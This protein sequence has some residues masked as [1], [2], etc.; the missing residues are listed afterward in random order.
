[1]SPGSLPRALGSRGH[2]VAV[3]M[4]YYRG[5]RIGKRPP[6]KTK[7]VVPVSVGERVLACRLYTSTLAASDVPIY[8]IDQPEYFDRD[9][10]VTGAGLYQQSMP[11]GYKS[12][13]PDNAERFAFFSR[14]VLEAP[15][16][17]ASLRILSMRT[18]G[19]PASCRCFSN[20]VF[21]ARAGWEK[22][23]S[24]FTIHN[25]AYQGMFGARRDAAHRP[26]RLALQP[27]A[28]RIP[29]PL[30]LPEVRHRLR[31][32]RQHRQPHLRPGDPDQP[33]SA[34]ASK[35]CS[36]SIATSSPAS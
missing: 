18:T 28:T 11:G 31:R 4:P 13:Y 8:F 2:D 9:D 26:A 33:S 32:R 23:R 5:I 36:A 10:P 29:R 15:S 6:E 30:Q 27:Q 34:A 24:I 20:E 25:I 19:R 16:P 17:S 14:A 3:V 22:A 7:Y 21:K 35:A 12:D 1:M